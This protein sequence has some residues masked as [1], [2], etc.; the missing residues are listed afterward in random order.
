MNIFS[1]I[2]AWIAMALLLCV[3]LTAQTGDP[4]LPPLPFKLSIDAP[5]DGE[6]FA[7]GAPITLRATAIDPAGAVLRLE[8]LA[9]NQRVGVS[10]ILTLVP[11]TPGEPVH[12][13]WVWKGAPPGRHALTVRAQSRQEFPVTSSPVNIVVG[14]EGGSSIRMES[15]TDGSVFST[16]GTVPMTVVTLDPLSEIR[17]V[18][19]WTD[20]QRLGVAEILTRDVIIP[21]RLRTLSFTWTN[22]PP[23]IHSLW[24]LGKDSSGTEIRSKPS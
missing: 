15:P 3:R 4:N 11:V 9:D 7:S 21:G 12:H 18:E 24:A 17:R 13:E 2:P 10:E 20:D 5:A 8:F 23:G 6:M 19:F 14:S 1:P 22:P 16:P